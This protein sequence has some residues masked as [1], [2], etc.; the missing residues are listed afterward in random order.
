MK[1][2]RLLPTSVRH[3]A[4]RKL[5]GWQRDTW[6]F[7]YKNRLEA[8]HWTVL[9]QDRVMLEAMEPD[10]NRREHLYEH[11]VGLS[12]L[13]RHKQSLAQKQIAAAQQAA[14]AKVA[15]PAATAKA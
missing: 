4:L 5:S 3:L 10:A 15:A 6:R 14:E 11:D 1:L 2:V 7:L 8:R 12:R 9:E 13:R